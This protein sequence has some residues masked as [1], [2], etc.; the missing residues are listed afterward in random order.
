MLKLQELRTAMGLSMRQ[1]ST[2]LEISYNTYLSYEKGTKE[3]SIST[4]IRMADFFDCSVDRLL[5]RNGKVISSLKPKEYDNIHAFAVRS[6]QLKQVIE[7]VVP[8][9]LGKP[10]DPARDI[11]QYWDMDGN[12]LGEV[13]KPVFL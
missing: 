3:P 12:L 8:L 9:G 6:V 5:G 7:T 11:I 4:L 10:G 2:Q 1:V 13:E